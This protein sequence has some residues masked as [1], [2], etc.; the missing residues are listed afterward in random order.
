[1]MFV[2]ALVGQGAGPIIVGLLSDM[3][4]A[5]FGTESLRLTLSVYTMVL[6]GSGACAWITSRT[7]TKDV[8][9]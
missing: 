2:S 9:N 7:M 6:V 8:V 4:T 3:F 5:S 1:M